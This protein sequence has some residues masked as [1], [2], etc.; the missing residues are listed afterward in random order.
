MVCTWANTLKYL[1]TLKEFDTPE[2][3]IKCYTKVKPT[4]KRLAKIFFSDPKTERDRASYRFFMQYIRSLGDF[5]ST[6][7]LRFLT[8]S[9]IIIIENTEVSFSAMEGLATRPI[10]HTCALMLELPN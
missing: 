1:K 2:S 7:F 9:D 4:T 3:V 8:G 5:E 10:A 6:K